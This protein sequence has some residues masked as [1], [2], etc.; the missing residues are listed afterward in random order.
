MALAILVFLGAAH[1]ILKS[2]PR[3]VKERSAGYQRMAPG[4]KKKLPLSYFDLNE[5]LK[6]P[7]VSG[8]NGDHFESQC[9]KWCILLLKIECGQALR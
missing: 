5:K 8:I 6:V 4:S 3:D 7:S 1:E 2:V 9:K